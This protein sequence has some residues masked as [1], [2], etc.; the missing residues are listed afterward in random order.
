MSR[1]SLGLEFFLIEGLG[2]DSVLRVKRL[3]LG[4]LLFSRTM[5]HFVDFRTTNKLHVI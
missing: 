2:F 4:G 3:D 5:R 1:S